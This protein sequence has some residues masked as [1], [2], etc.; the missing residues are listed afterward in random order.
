MLVMD[1]LPFGSWEAGGEISNRLAAVARI[2]GRKAKSYGTK[3]LT[4]LNL[5]PLART[6]TSTKAYISK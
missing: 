2:P 5:E 3:L 1:A 4:P 6:Q